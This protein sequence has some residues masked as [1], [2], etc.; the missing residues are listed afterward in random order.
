ME[1]ARVVLAEVRVGA[2]GRDFAL[3]ANDEGPI[4][5]KLAV[6]EAPVHGVREESRGSDGFIPSGEELRD[7]MLGDSREREEF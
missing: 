3:G 1:S 4:F 2:T 5:K 7:L 6:L